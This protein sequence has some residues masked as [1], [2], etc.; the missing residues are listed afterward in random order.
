[1][2][3]EAV[4]GVGEA[5]ALVV[6]GGDG[7]AGFGEE[8]GG[9]SHEPAGLAGEAVDDADCAEDK[10]R[11]L[12]GPGLG[13]EAEAA[14]VGDVG[15]GVG[16]VVAGVEGGGGVVA[17]GAGGVSLRHRVEMRRRRRHRWCVRGE[18]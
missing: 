10:G 18:G 5:V 8:D 15:G 13:E 6:D 16:D 9:E 4:E 2:N 14:W 7:E 17:E 11:G 12:W 1:M 3:G